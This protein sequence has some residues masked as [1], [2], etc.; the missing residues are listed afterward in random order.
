MT[1]ITP[2]TRE[3]RLNA[4]T[5]DRRL[6]ARSGGLASGGEA[7]TGIT[8]AFHCTYDAR[9]WRDSWGGLHFRASLVVD[10]HETRVLRN[11][12]QLQEVTREGNETTVLERYEIDRFASPAAASRIGP[13][14]TGRSSTLPYHIAPAV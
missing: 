10:K 11:V 1:V 13:V 9:G 2:P 7:A 4:V 5:C 3:R 14:R 8:V 12:V 6:A